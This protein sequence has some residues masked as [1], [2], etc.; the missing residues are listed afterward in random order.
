MIDDDLK[1]VRTRPVRYSDRIMFQFP[2]IMLYTR[3]EIWPV[4]LHILGCI[5]TFDDG[6][7]R[8]TLAAS[9]ITFPFSGS[10]VAQTED[11]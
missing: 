1:G 4:M 2:L 6:K 10:D 9:R 11:L 3:L 5:V 7:G 8:T